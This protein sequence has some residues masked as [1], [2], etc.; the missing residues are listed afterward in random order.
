MVKV[1]L[2]P[3]VGDDD[4]AAGGPWHVPRWRGTTGMRAI[5]RWRR[6]GQ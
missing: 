3:Q 6:S 1:R 4:L 5:E 2:D